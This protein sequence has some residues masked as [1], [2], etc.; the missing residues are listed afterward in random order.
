MSEMDMCG[1]G[2][3]YAQSMETSSRIPLGL[4]MKI[5]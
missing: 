1:G 5:V 2:T 4:S 3:V